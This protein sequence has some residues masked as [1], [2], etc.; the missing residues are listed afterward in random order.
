MGRKHPTFLGGGGGVCSRDAG[1][2]CTQKPF[3]GRS[4]TCRT[5]ALMSQVVSPSCTARCAPSS[6]GLEPQP[7][8]PLPPSQLCATA[9]T[10]PVLGTG[11][12]RNS[13][14]LILAFPRTATRSRG[15]LH[16]KASSRDC[17]LPPEY[18]TCEGDGL[19]VSTTSKA[20]PWDATM[21][22][23]CHTAPRTPLLC[24]TECS[25]QHPR[26]KGSSTSLQTG[27]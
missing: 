7:A 23:S 2:Q 25:P 5:S 4:H 11:C 26:Q 3:C 24:P 17:F 12:L 15:V 21:G 8:V 22:S 6:V 18:F 19:P 16:P 13:T 20:S 1:W 10:P 14:Q 9:G 27:I